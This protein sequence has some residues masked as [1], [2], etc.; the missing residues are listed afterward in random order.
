MQ[1]N[2]LVINGKTLSM[3]H[4][5][6]FELTFEVAA[7]ALTVKFEFG[8]HCFTDEKGY[9][10]KLNHKGE[11]R[12]FC[13]S[14]YHCSNQLRDY[15]ERRFFKGGCAPTTVKTAVVNA[16]SVWICTTTRSFFRS[17]NGVRGATEPKVH[18]SLAPTRKPLCCLGSSIKPPFYRTAAGIIWNG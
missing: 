18:L 13:P 6:P 14:R 11:Q 4:M 3:S 8:F 9:G 16:I 17:A 2:D 7:E 1:W 10:E 5:Q 15:I 12:Y